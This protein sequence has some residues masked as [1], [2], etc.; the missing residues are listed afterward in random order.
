MPSDLR[1]GHSIRRQHNLVV[2]AIE[3]AIPIPRA[4][5]VAE[6]NPAREELKA[7][8]AQKADIDRTAVSQVRRELW[9]G[10]GYLVVQTAGFMR[11]TFWELSWDVMEPICFYVTSMYFM[12]GYAFFLRT[13]K[14]PSFEG[15]FESRFAAKQKRL[16]LARDF[17]LRRYNELRRACG[18]SLTTALQAPSPCTSPSQDSHCHSYC[19]C[20]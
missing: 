7:M 5:P 18:L 12:A 20:H 10:L 17:D 14:E 4:L 3:K 6:D 1:L 19:H 2:E 8:E 11:L 9:L 16:M 13:K 15:F